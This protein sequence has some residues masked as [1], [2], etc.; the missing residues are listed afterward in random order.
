MLNFFLGQMFGARVFAGTLSTITSKT[1]VPWG[2]NRIFV[3]STTL[4]TH[5]MKNHLIMNILFAPLNVKFS[6][7]SHFI[8][9]LDKDSG[10]FTYLSQAF[11]ELAIEMYNT[12]TIDSNET[13]TS[14]SEFENWMKWNWHHED[15]GSGPGEISWQQQDE[16][17][18]IICHKYDDCSRNL[19]W[20]M[21]IKK[22]ISNSHIWIVLLRIE[23]PWATACGTDSIR[24]Y[25]IWKPGVDNL[26]CSSEWRLQL[27]FQMRHFCSSAF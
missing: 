5:L 14:E 8:N 18:H 1:I 26:E 17:L 4:L 10:Y 11:P 2:R 15:F 16:E 27:K 12:S 25:L 9:T 23:D 19:R 22:C 3:D 6:L 21:K 24:T 13:L 7:I 20:S